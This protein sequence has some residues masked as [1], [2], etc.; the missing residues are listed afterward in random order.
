MET[1]GIRMWTNSPDVH[2]IAAICLFG[3]ALSSAVSQFIEISLKFQFNL[4]GVCVIATASV[5]NPLDPNP[6]G[7]SETELD[8]YAAKEIGMKFH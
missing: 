1:T 7:L 5:V 3:N 6:D 4:L 8:T 2:R